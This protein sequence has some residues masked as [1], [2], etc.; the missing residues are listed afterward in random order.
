M[1]SSKLTT[2]QRLASLYIDGD[3]DQ[4]ELVELESLLS[5]DAKARSIFLDLLTT[6]SDLT[7]LASFGISEANLASDEP[8]THLPNRQSQQGHAKSNPAS[9]RGFYLRY[10]AAAVALTACAVVAMFLIPKTSPMPVADSASGSEAE[11]VARIIRKI[12]CDWEG[13]HWDIVSSSDVR[14]GQTLMMRRG[15]MELEFTSGA[16][17]TLEG[18]VAFTAESPMNAYLSQGKLTTH[19]PESAQG[20]TVNSPGVQTVDLGTEFGLFVGEDGTTETHVFD[21]E[22]IVTPSFSKDR[23]EILLSNDMAIRAG[24]AEQIVSSLDAVPA[25]FAYCNFKEKDSVAAPIVDRELALWFSAEHLVQVDEKNRVR[26]WG[27]ITSESNENAEVAWQV[28]EPKRPELI[29]SAIGDKPAL[30]FTKKTVMVTEPVELT[31]EQTIVAVFKIDQAAMEEMGIPAQ[32]GRQLINLNGPPH[33]SLRIND[34]F[35]LT[36]QNFA[37]VVKTKKGKKQY[38]TVGRL[39]YPK[40]LDDNAVV[41][42]SIYSPSSNASKLYINGTLVDE[43]KA[44]AMKMTKSPRY[45]GAHMFLPRTNFLGDIAE[46]MVYDTALTAEETTSVSHSLVVKYGIKPKDAKI[47]ND[48]A[49]IDSEADNSK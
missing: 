9:N 28:D 2:L 30:R 42:V 24:G 25:R 14:A 4:S 6:H 40:V 1:E 44:P 8:T 33:L 3:L 13:D 36:S 29:E 5:E 17:V 7:L 21:G 37:G 31:G 38:R 49:N 46:L 19:V 41:V 26:S 48:D 23:K 16:R 12:D 27:D 47:Q 10:A 32:N 45:L 11:I 43:A 39:K 35:Q 18:P 22:V 34:K 15:L 20:F